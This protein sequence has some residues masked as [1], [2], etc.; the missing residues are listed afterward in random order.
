[1]NKF[2]YFSLRNI[3]CIDH[4]I[5]LVSLFILYYFIRKQANNNRS[6]NHSKSLNNVDYQPFRNLLHVTTYH[7]K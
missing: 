2:L 4:A 1:M 5:E 7:E 3:A 6:S